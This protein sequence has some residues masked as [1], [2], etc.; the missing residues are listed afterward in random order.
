MALDI[1]ICGRKIFFLL[2]P[3]LIQNEIIEILSRAEYEVYSIMDPER[4]KLLLSHYPESMVYI[5]V[6]TYMSQPEWLNYVKKLRQSVATDETVFSLL[7]NSGNE[8][9]KRKLVYDFEAKGGIVTV[10]TDVKA[11]VDIIMNQLDQYKCHGRRKY[12]RTYCENDKLAKLNFI[13]NEHKFDLKIRD[14]SVFGTCAFFTGTYRIPLKPKQLIKNALL[15]LRGLN[16]SCDILVFNINEET[17]ST[18]FVFLFANFSESTGKDK[19]RK[20]VRQSL[21]AKINS[22]TSYAIKDEE[23][24]KTQ[25]GSQETSKTE[26]QNTNDSSQQ[27]KDTQNKESL[28]QQKPETQEKPNN[29]DNSEEIAE[30]QN[31]DILVNSDETAQSDSSLGDMM[32]M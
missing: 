2:P 14:I 13:C 7:T 10:R 22:I 25:S 17:Y 24:Q 9:L 6:D 27:D 15:S 20:Y 12:V 4:M 18:T 5:N 3:P 8:E 26:N 1:S 21:Q 29:P 11:T 31:H 28:E 16:I 30:T 19:I 23:K 32:G